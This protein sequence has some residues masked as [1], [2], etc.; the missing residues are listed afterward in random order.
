MGIQNWN[1]L[2]QVSLVISTI[3]A[4]ISTYGIFSTGREIE[5]RN[6]VEKAKLREEVRLEKRKI[7]TL[8]VRLQVTFMPLW[9]NP[10]FW[11]GYSSILKNGNF[12]VLL[13]EDTEGDLSQ[14]ELPNYERSG[15]YT[16]FNA[17][18]SLVGKYPSNKDYNELKKIKGLKI[19]LPF[20]H[21][22]RAKV[23][24]VE[25][26]SMKLSFALNGLEEV[27]I[28][29]ESGEVVSISKAPEDITQ[30][31]AFLRPRFETNLYDLL[32]KTN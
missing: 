14:I 8:L 28:L 21:L 17:N 4:G 11:N 25:I 22:D 13:G 1:Y 27:S 23:H 18:F 3:T 30:G 5:K 20:F 19:L 7:R 9:E 16:T 6:E 15:E 12:L 10:D 26:K 32:V 31:Q 2:W 29:F 24:K